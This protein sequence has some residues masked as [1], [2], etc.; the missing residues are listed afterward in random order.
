M[1][2]KTGTELEQGRG[3]REEERNE[4]GKIYFVMGKSASGK[5]TIYKKLLERIPELKTIIPYTTRPMREGE[6]EGAEYHFTDEASL[7][8]MWEMG[9]VIDSP[10][11]RA[12]RAGRIFTTFS[13]IMFGCL[14]F[15]V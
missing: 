11:L 13:T 4:Y 10:I 2:Q 1:K 12:V 6:K 8:E 5:D 7:Q 14:M 3:Q 15:N 9:K